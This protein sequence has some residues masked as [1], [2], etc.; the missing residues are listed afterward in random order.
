MSNSLLTI[1]EIT[2]E[3]LRIL[4]GNLAFVKGIDRQYDPQF[5]KTGAKIGST[6][7]IRKPNKY[8]VTDGRVMDVQDT[9][10]QYTSLTISTQKHVAMNFT[11]EEL[12]LKL[13]DFSER[14]IAPAMSVLA[15]AVDY[16]CL[17]MSL[18][19]AQSVGT[20]GTTP[21]NLQVWLDA[22]AYL[23][24][25]LA[26][27]DDNRMVVCSPQAMARTVYGNLGLFH[28]SDSIS[29][30]YR[31]G[32]LKRGVGFKWAMDQN[33]RNLTT[34]TNTNRN[35]TIDLAANVSTGAT[36]ISID[37]LSGAT[38]TFTDGEVF[39]IAG[40]Y[41][42]N[43]ET[44]QSTG[45]LKQFAVNGN[46]TGSGSAVTNLAITPTIYGPTSGALQNVSALPASGDDLVFYGTTAS[47]TYPQS[48]AFHRDAFTFATA[49]LPLPKAAQQASRQMK[50]G[51]SLRVWQGD[52]IINDQF[53]CRVD[54]L[55]GFNAN[56]PELACRVWG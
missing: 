40:V 12:A 53:P 37:G 19:V 11:S 44:K 46:F 56:Y 7:R 45:R 39:T 30:Q 25:S 18:D 32:F 28:E 20:P 3:S 49:D 17:S 10:G 8:S 51:I 31:M 13:D 33:I 21:A 29:D 15:A 4:H 42:V 14:I 43:A 9:V 2:R 35:T 52:D 54:V 5:A 34:G 27:R 6:L 55:Y 26:P 24:E 48:L 23:D 41:D 47:T 1:D 16:D 50:D 36:T 38:V 22:G